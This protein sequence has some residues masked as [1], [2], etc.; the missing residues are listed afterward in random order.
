M[1]LDNHYKNLL[2]TG[3]EKLSVHYP[4]SYSISAKQLDQLLAYHQLLIK[5]NKAYNLTAIRDPEAMIS[6]HLLDSLSIVPFLQGERFI[7]VGTG[8]GLPGIVL[9]IL[10]PNCSLDLLDS[11]GKKTRFLFQVK[12]D[13]KLSNVII[14]HQRVEHHKPDNLYDAVLSRAFATLS[15]MAKGSDHLVSE[16]GCFFAMKGIYPD[17]ELKQLSNMKKSYTV[18]A[19]HPLIVP[20]DNSDRHLVV[21]TASV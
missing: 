13:L 9:A 10:F 11:N 21:F 4:D 2:L 14:H 5:W 17:E 6:R 15:D 20:G 3:I 7:D 19:C 1:R 16:Q 12:T 8:A 18:K